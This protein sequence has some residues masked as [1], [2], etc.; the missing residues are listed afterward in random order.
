MT[1]SVKTARKVA[2]IVN[3]DADCRR[4][5][6]NDFRSWLLDEAGLTG[7]ARNLALLAIGPFIGK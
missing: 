2:D 6:R 4:V 1:L 5:I 7:A 3:S